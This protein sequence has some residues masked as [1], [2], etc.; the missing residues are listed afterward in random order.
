ML[1]PA[2]MINDGYTLRAVNRELHIT[3][4]YRPMLQWE[5]LWMIRADF[6][7]SLHNDHLGCASTAR[8]IR[9]KIILWN[10]GDRPDIAQFMHWSDEKT[11]AWEWIS[12]TVSGN[13]EQQK[14]DEENIATGVPLYIRYRHLGPDTCAQCQQ[15]LF[16]P[17]TGEFETD[18][19]DGS[20]IPRFTEAV[21]ACQTEEGCP[22]GTPDAPRSLS[23]RNFMALRHYQ[24]CRS[25]G[26]FPDDPIV[27]RNASLFSQAIEKSIKAIRRDAN[28]QQAGV[29]AKTP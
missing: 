6:D 4:D 29:S 10:G 18:D 13:P 20:R 22:N 1:T 25:V 28:E 11:P 15:F 17:E 14:L 7:Y 21:L 2:T 23:E 26:S 9:D 5:R 16:D 19:L 12:E 27:R 24:Q 3:L 8:C